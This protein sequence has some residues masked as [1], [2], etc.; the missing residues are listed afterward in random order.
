MMMNRCFSLQ[1]PILLL[2]SVVVLIL[3]NSSCIDAY[4]IRSTMHPNLN[5]FAEAQLGKLMDIRFVIQGN[6]KAQ[7]AS[8]KLALQGPMVRFMDQVADK[9]M[10][11][12]MPA[13]SHYRH[14]SSG[15][16][17]LDIVKEGF[18]VDMNGRK[19]IPFQNGSWEMTWKDGQRYGSIVCGFDLPEAVRNLRETLLFVLEISTPCWSTDRKGNK[20]RPWS[21]HPY[22]DKRPAAHTEMEFSPYYCRYHAIKSLFLPAMFLLI[23]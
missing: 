7:E 2:L 15:A 23:S 18:V 13:S 20:E 4:L 16:K 8:S 11:N 22:K 19:T 9:I 5:Q 12:V 14:L 10:K 21:P 6:S 17:S 1:F 3:Q